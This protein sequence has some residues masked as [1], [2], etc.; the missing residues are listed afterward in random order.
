MPCQRIIFN[1][2]KGV[3]A[4]RVPQ[5]GLKGAKYRQAQSGRWVEKRKPMN[6]TLSLRE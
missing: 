3:D 1:S 6:D 4:K 2:K 5:N